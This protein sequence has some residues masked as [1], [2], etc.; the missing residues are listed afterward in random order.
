VKKLFQTLTNS[1]IDQIAMLYCNSIMFTVKAFFILSLAV[2][3]NAVSLRGNSEEPKQDRRRLAAYYSTSDPNILG[4]AN[5]DAAIGNPLKGLVASPSWTGG[6]TKYTIPNSLEFTYVGMKSVMKGDNQFDWTMLDKTLADAASRN[7]HVIWRI[8]VDYPGWPFAMPQY[9]IDAG[10]KLVP[11]SDGGVSPQYDDPTLLRAF[12]QLITAMGARYDGH[13]SIGF[14]QLGLLG[15]WGEWHTYPENN[16]LSDATCDKVI[17]WYKAAFKT[18]K[19]QTRGAS[20][21]SIAAGMGLHDDSFAY[22]TLGNVGWF[23][24]PRLVSAGFTDFWKNSPMGGE[25]RP[26]LQGTIFE[27]SY[28]PAPDYAYKQDFMKCVETTHATY[29]LT[30]SA[31]LANNYVGAEL[32]NAKRAHARMGY[33]YQVTNVAVSSSVSP[34]VVV[35]EV[36]VKQIGVAPFYYP[37]NLALNCAG[38]TETLSGVETLVEPGS[39]KVFTYAAIPADATCLGNIR[40]SLESPFT[41]AGKPIKFAQ[42]NGSVVF[43]L[44]L[45][46]GSSPRAAPVR[47]PSPAPVRAATPAPVRAATPAPVRAATPAPVRAA[48]LAPVRAATPAPVQAATP[49]PV[50][51]P[52]PAPLAPVSVFF[53]DARTKSGPQFT[54]TS[55]TLTTTGDSI[56]GTVGYQGDLFRHHRWSKGF[57]YTI[58][59]FV[60]GTSYA[61][62]MGFAETFQPNCGTGKRVFSVF[63]NGA[64]VLSSLDVFALV[65]CK[66]A[67]TTTQT[68][69]AGANRKMELK[70]VAVKQNPFVSFIDV[71]TL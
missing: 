57:T 18:T 5:P 17:Q 30:H 61:V 63:A 2:V 15:K 23:F 33:N 9:L 10:V 40:L 36:T 51:L 46:T 4:A 22:S 42:G 52:A 3:G 59:G 11:R 12:Q 31:F 58:S 25:T 6:V 24:W 54:L 28:V 66:K 53:V 20:S 64:T 32:E 38:T 43:S 19:L 26:E 71:K 48:T 55:T 29:M 14:I 1:Q 8:Y 21:A 56:A 13:K 68:V 7:N 44:P 35:V 60:P 16:L 62:T 41:Y 65:G 50:A 45:P 47:P 27:P 34:G 49:A 67:Y 37:L 69:V 70:F 39:T